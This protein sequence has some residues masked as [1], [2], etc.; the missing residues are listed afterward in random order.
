MQEELLRTFNILSRL[1]DSFGE[2]V[3][4][5][6]E[7]DEQDSNLEYFGKM[8]IELRDILSKLEN[9]DTQLVDETVE[10]LLQLHLKFSDYIWHTDQIHELVKKMAGNYRDSF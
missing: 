1:N 4:S 6:E 5:Q 9:S 10:T 7:L 3:I 8:V 2:K